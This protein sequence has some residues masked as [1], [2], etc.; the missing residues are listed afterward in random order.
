MKKYYPGK[1][2]LFRDLVKSARAN[3][4]K[5]IREKAEVEAKAKLT[6]KTTQHIP[7]GCDAGINRVDASLWIW[8]NRMPK[9]DL[10][11]GYNTLDRAKSCATIQKSKV[12]PY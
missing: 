11:V 4:L 12:T 9:L 2:R 5:A 1:L 10:P 6:N 3:H 8:S 7:Q